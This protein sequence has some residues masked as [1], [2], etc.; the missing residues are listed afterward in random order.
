MAKFPVK[1]IVPYERI[2]HA[3]GSVTRIHRGLG[4]ERV[5]TQHTDGRSTQTCKQMGRPELAYSI[6]NELLAY[7]LRA[8]G[9][10]HFSWDVNAGR[11]ILRFPAWVPPMALGA[12]PVIAFVRRAVRRRRCRQKGLCVRCGY[13]LTG[14][15]SGICPECGAKLEKP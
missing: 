11:L 12:Y 10:I 1:A 13:N 8:R 5:H 6:E 4:Y 14:N 7:M 15:V 9:L 2:D 3:D